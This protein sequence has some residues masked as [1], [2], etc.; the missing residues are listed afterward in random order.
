MATRPKNGNVFIGAYD[1]NNGAVL[2]GQSK[3]SHAFH[4]TAHH[5]VI[6][7]LIIQNY[8]APAQYGMIQIWGPY[9]LIQSNEITRATAGAGVWVG[10]YA[11]ARYLP[12]ARRTGMTET[13]RRWREAPPGLFPLPHPSWRTTG[14]ERR[15][16][17]FTA[18]TLPDLRRRVAAAISAAGRAA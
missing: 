7:N 17:W 16:P 13:V 9:A 10:S 4:G 14:W 2:D 1:G 15:N 5:V 18:E 8:T 12:D 11:L 6:K 3:T